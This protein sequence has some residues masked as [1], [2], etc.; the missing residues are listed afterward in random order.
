[1]EVRGRWNRRSATP[2]SPAAADFAALLR[3][4]AAS[5]WETGDRAAAVEC[6]NCALAIEV[7]MADDFPPEGLCPRCKLR[8]RHVI[9][10]EA[11]G[12]TSLDY[13]KWCAECLAD[14]TPALS[15]SS[16]R[17]PSEAAKPPRT[18]DYVAGFA[19][20]ETEDRVALILKTRPDWQRGRLNGIGGHIEVGET[21]LA[22]MQREFEE[23]TGGVADWTLFTVLRGD[24]FGVWFFRGIATSPLESMTDEVVTWVDPA[25][26]PENVLPNLRWLIPMARSQQSWD[27][28]FEIHERA[29]D[30]PPS[31][32][33]TT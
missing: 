15:P 13:A 2:A 10:W 27:W 33:T 19:F 14:D 6:E 24:G 9:A 23:E 12:K 11:G 29:I 5:K 20:S 17:E 26:L 7:F 16:P 31:G 22:A 8:E 1:M 28:P 18:T 4:R 30:F 32:G 21:P 25:N 3:R